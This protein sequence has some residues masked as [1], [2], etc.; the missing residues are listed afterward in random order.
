M[1]TTTAFQ[2]MYGRL[3]D[4][5]GR[6]ST[7]LFALVVFLLGSGLCGVADSLTFMNISRAIAGIGGGGIFTC[8]SIMFSDLVSLRERGRIQGFGNAAFGLGSMIGAPLGGWLSDTLNW[9]WAFWINLPLGLAPLFIITFMVSD[10]NL[11]KDVSII[12]KLKQVDYL[13]IMALASSMCGIVL[14]LSLGGNELP[15]TDPVVVGSLAGGFL[16]LGVFVLIESKV[17]AQPVMPLEILKERTPMSAYLVNFFS[18]MSALS[19]VF[20][21]PLWFQALFGQSATQSGLYLIPKIVSSSFGSI[22]SGYF[23]ART[24][25]YLGLTWFSCFCM[26]LAEGLILGLWGPNSKEIEYAGFLIIDGFGFGSMLTTTLVSM[27]AALPV[28]HVAVGSAVSYLFRSTGSV[29]G[30]AISQ[31]TLQAVLKTRLES[32]VKGPDAAKIIDVARRSVTE[33][34]TVLPRETL[35]KFVVPAYQDA[36]RAGFIVCLTCSSL[37]FLASLGQYDQQKGPYDQQ[38]YGSQPPPYPPQQGYAAQ[39]VYAQPQ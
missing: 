39:P 21:V 22:M 37:A 25:T 20:L 30:V 29:L 34:W 8:S 1:L 28:K 18:S 33:M 2:P 23:M 3:S 5:F 36:L 4:I 15:W 35:E 19:S 11:K 24:G 10:Y 7:M 26:V 9:R 13:G 31:A 14:A 16:L 27:L 6:K 12:Q 17:A 32:T 38:P